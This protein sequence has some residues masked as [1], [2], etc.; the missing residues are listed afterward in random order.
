MNEE[1]KNINKT[2]ID[3]SHIEFAIISSKY[4]LFKFKNIIKKK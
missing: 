4:C 3:L 2:K 1:N